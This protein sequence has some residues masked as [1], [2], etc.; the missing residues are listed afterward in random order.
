VKVWISDVSCKQEAYVSV[1]HD[2]AA[3]DKAH[4]DDAYVAEHDEVD[5]A[6]GEGNEDILQVDPWY[7]EVLHSAENP[8]SS[9]GVLLQRH[10]CSRHA[11]NQDA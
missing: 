11:T 9:E 4:S 5:S 6:K 7:I 3:E 10:A 1:H 2:E 8:T